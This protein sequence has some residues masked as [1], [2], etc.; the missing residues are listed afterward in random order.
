[1]KK[2]FLTALFVIVVVCSNAWATQGH[3]DPEGLYSHQIAHFFFMFSMVFLIVQIRRSSPR[4]EGWKYIGAAAFLFLLWNIDVF[5]V[6]WIRE[7]ITPDYFTGSVTEW[8]Q[9]INISS[10]RAKLFYSGKIID[11]VLTVSALTVF[12]LGIRAFMRRPEGE[13]A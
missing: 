8:S 11:H 13:E 3:D 12:I 10:W 7:Y 4:H 9:T 1:M 5:A 6:H 2:T